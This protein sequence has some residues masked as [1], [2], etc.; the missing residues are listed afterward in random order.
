MIFF[1]SFI[2]DE[3]KGNEKDGEKA[4]RFFACASNIDSEIK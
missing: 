4:M 3:N 1:F 2:I